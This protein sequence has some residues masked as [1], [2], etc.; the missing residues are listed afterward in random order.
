[1]R[2]SMYALAPIVLVIYFV[3]YPA[4]LSTI[5]SQVLSFLR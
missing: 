1:M 4:H 2:E 3:L 5:A